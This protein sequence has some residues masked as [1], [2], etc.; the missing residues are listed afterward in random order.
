MAT[1]RSLND[2][3]YGQLKSTGAIVV[4][5]KLGAMVRRYRRLKKGH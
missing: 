3:F 5:G 1:R 2:N 4:K